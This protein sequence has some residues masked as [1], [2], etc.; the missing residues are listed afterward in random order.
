MPCNADTIVKIKVVKE[1]EKEKLLVV[2]AIGVYPVGDE[3]NEI[4]LVM[5][6]PV[7]AEERDLAT[8]AIFERDE[9]FSVG[10]KI[11]PEHYNN[12]IRPRMMVSTSTHLKI[13]NKAPALNKCP[14][15]VSLIGVVGEV[16]KF[17]NEED[18]IIKVSITDYSR[19][20]YNFIVTVV[21][22]YLDSC[23]KSLA[24]LIRQENRWFLL[25]VRWSL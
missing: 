5:F 14:L 1:T 18:A 13:L 11:V 16:P 4:E 24:S 21:F 9:Y 7:K 22:R 3:D 12:N 2:C 8:Q 20:N 19:R 15:K 17:K 10:G 23:F 6:V 25:L